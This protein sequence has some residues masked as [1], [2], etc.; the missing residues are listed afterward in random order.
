[1]RTGSLNRQQSRPGLEWMG[2]MIVRGVADKAVDLA[3]LMRGAEEE[4]ESLSDNSG[5]FSA[6][7]SDGGRVNE[8]SSV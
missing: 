8:C 7:V 6:H 5:I 3:E 4:D 2:R 1:M